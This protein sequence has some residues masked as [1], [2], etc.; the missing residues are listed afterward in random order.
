MTILKKVVVS[1]YTTPITRQKPFRYHQL[2]FFQEETKTQNKPASTNE[3]ILA[4]CAASS[5]TTAGM[6]TNKRAQ[7][8]QVNCR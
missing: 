2:I 1:H 7:T 8:Q 4:R 5:V 3:E 6:L